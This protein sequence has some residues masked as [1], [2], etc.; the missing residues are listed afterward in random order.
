M[1][2]ITLNHILSALTN[3]KGAA[4]DITLSSV[5][6]DS[7]RVIPGALFIA[8]PGEK[9]NG[10]Q[11]VADAFQHGALIALIQEI[12]PNQYP[13]VNLEEITPMGGYL[14]PQTPFC[15]LVKDSLKAM[16]IC[17]KYWRRQLT[18]EVI[19]IT[20]SVGKSTTKELVAE[21]LSQKYRTYK[22]P[23]N[24]NNEVGLPLSV[25]NL[26]S[27]YEKA[28]LEMGFYYPGEISFL[29]DIALPRIG[30]VTNIGTV[31]AERAGSKEEI[32]K[33]KSELVQALPPAPEGVAI[34]N[35]DDPFVLSMSEKTNAR[36][37]T[38][39][40]DPKADLWADQF[41]GKGLH[42]IDFHMHYQGKEHFI[43][44]SLY[45]KHSVL[46][47]LRAAA[48]GIVEGLTIEQIVA[49]LQNGQSQL[50]MVAR[51][52]SMGAL[53]LDDSYN[54]S[55][56]STIAALDLLEEIEGRHI[57]ILGD[58]LEL[59]PY[60]L[61]GHERVGNYAAHL[62][63]QLIAVGPRSKALADSALKAGLPAS[64]IL[65][66]E[67]SQQ[68]AEPLRKLLK[69]GDVALIKGSHGMRMDRIIS[70]IEEIE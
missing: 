38:Y 57:A 62:V 16:Q 27:G 48:A 20:G 4:P 28:V 58:M 13:V 55:P 5:S 61:S 60:E 6:I 67:T 8:L 3:F 22:N 24:Y 10:H 59:G 53:I 1:T 51:Q 31:H 17:A 23:G 41:K 7:R 14:F 63:D 21:V 45:G 68:A 40:L 29:C 54:A 39:G 30:I 34:L 65:W 52:T 15:L 18:V 49:G 69:K 11:F 12:I 42:G 44:T 36:V 33:G 66:V 56:E 19:G 47:C 50:R 43:H 46:T 35:F 25:L 26:G 32:A 64:S 2:M 37:F 9:V 70:A